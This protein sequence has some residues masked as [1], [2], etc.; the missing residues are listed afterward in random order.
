MYV[1]SEQFSNALISVLMR[2]DPIDDFRK[3]YRGVDVLLLDDVQFLAGKG[4]CLE[5]F[6]HTFNDLYNAG[7]QIVLSSDKPPHEIVEFEERVRSRFAWGLKMCI[8]DR[9]FFADGQQRLHKIRR[10]TVAITKLSAVYFYNGCAV[11]Y[12][13]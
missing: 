12:D 8:R 9:I 3:Q 10:D 5:E 1:T 13:A 7:K 6:F 11:I 4:R 2:K